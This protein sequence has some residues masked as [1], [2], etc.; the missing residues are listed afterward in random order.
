MKKAEYSLGCILTLTRNSDNTVLDEANATN[1]PE[2]KIRGIEWCVP[3]YTP[4]IP[5]QAILSKQFLE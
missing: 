3:R 2:I 5:Q 4:S 1:S